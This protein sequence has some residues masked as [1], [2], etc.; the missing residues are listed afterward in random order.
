MSADL[1]PRAFRATAAVSGTCEFDFGNSDMESEVVA[2][3][4]IGSERRQNRLRGDQK[5]LAVVQVFRTASSRQRMKIK[6]C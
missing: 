4:E 6:S 2:E 5:L 1:G 3:G